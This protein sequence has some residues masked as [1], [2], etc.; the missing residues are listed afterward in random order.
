MVRQ[1]RD[2]SQLRGAQTAAERGKGRRR[3]VAPWKIAASS[4]NFTGGPR[5]ASVKALTGD[6]AARGRT[7]RVLQAAARQP[8]TD[9]SRRGARHGAARPAAP[10]ARGTGGPARRCR[11]ERRHTVCIAGTGGGA[12][13]V[14]AVGRRGCGLAGSWLTFAC[15]CRAVQHSLRQEGCGPLH[16]GVLCAD[17]E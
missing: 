9:G 10:R 1:G 11:A 12:G 17:G 6:A 4:S 5:A 15:V 16:P 2:A 13:I 14:V 3:T 7:R 8:V